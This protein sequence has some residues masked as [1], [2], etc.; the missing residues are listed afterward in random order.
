[1]TLSPIEALCYVKLEYDIAMKK[2]SFIILV[3]LVIAGAGGYLGYRHFHHN[4]PVKSVNTAQAATKTTSTQTT[5]NTK[6]TSTPSY[7]VGDTQKEGSLTIKLDST[8]SGTS[9]EQL[10]ANSTV[11]SV[12]IT[13]TNNDPITYVSPD[14]FVNESSVYTQ[15][16]TD[17]STG[18][19]IKAYTTP[20]F[21]GGD[22]TIAPNQSLS[23]C[24]QFIVPSNALVD[25][26]FY[27]NLK[28]YL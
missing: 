23:G 20:C 28:W 18:Q 14:A 4:P 9:M 2:S 3:V 25:T 24:V 15:V 5:N 6:A 13:V 22:A 19:Y 16:G 1:M 12:N 11:F 17:T 27:N 10:P 21:G 26:Y 7:Y 8:G